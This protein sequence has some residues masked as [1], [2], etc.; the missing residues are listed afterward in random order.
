MSIPANAFMNNRFRVEIDGITMSDFAEVVLPDVRADVVEYRSGGSPQ[1]ARKDPGQIHVGSLVLRR[2]VTKSDDLFTWWKEVADGT[3]DRRSVVVV[4][5]DRRGRAVKRWTISRTWPARY[6]VAP[7][8]AAD[9]KVT[10]LETLEFAAEGFQP[11][12]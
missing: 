7:L 2:G 11:V 4:L 5:Q 3:L 12:P 6:S 8:I 1:M 10:L 9:S